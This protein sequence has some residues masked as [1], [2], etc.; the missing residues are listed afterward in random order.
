MKGSSGNKGKAKDTTNNRAI[1]CSLCVPFLSLL[2][3][4]AIFFFS[5]FCPNFF[6]AFAL[7]IFFLSKEHTTI[8]SKKFELNWIKDVA[9]RKS[10]LC[11]KKHIKT[12]GPE[13]SIFLIKF[14]K[15]N[16]YKRSFAIIKW[17]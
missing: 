11:F 10:G 8:N 3:S 13:N 7:L 14:C 16:F 1:E 6:L 15:S 9:Y 17:I 5:F 2:F 4:F 12:C